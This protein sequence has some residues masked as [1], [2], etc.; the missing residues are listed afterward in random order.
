MGSFVTFAQS[1]MNSVFWRFGREML[2]LWVFCISHA[3]PAQLPISFTSLGPQAFVSEQ[4]FI[5]RSDLF[6]YQPQCMRHC[7]KSGFSCE[8]MH[9]C[10]AAFL[11]VGNQSS[12]FWAFLPP[13]IEKPPHLHPSNSSIFWAQRIGAF[14]KNIYPKPGCIF[15]GISFLS[16]P[17]RRL[18]LAL[19]VVLSRGAQGNHTWPQ[20]D[21]K[22]MSVGSSYPGMHLASWKHFA[23][24]AREFHTHSQHA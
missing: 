9:F 20:W 22:V 15:C 1:G 16:V 13:H 11:L 3:A 5:S 8:T 17:L 2:K 14:K 4:W 7:W 19:C 6:L 24:D 12:T 21:V 23:T 18:M 10:R